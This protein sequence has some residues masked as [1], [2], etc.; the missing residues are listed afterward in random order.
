MS[1]VEPSESADPTRS[2]I[3]DGRKYLWDGTVF[4]SYNDASR[5][6][7]AYIND[8]FEVHFVESGQKYLVYSRRA[9]KEIDVTAR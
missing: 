2:I 6:A 7:E 8:S 1:M 3:V 5:Q 4:E 9:V